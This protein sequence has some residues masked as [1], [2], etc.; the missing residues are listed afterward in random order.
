MKTTTTINALAYPV[1][2]L[3]KRTG[4]Q[5]DDTVV[6]DKSW[7]QICGKL[8]I[9][10]DK[11]IIYRIYNTKGYVVLEI[12]K[13]RKLQLTVDLEELYN[14][15]IRMEQLQAFG[16]VNTATQPDNQEAEDSDE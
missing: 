5:M 4:E 8:D 1:K 3:D 14:K 7:L 9:A 6:L 13:R 2:I 12:G 11:Q 16:E 10:D 15:Q